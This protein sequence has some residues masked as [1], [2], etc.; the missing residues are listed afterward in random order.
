MRLLLG[1]LSFALLLSATAAGQ[2]KTD[3]E[4]AGLQGAV[5]SVRVE[6]VEL[7]ADGQTSKRPRWLTSV[8][9]YDQQGN[10]LE[11]LHYQPNGALREKRTVARDNEGHKVITTYNAG[12]AVTA[13]TVNSYDDAGHITGTLTYDGAGVLKHKSAS[14]YDE[15]GRFTGGAVYN[16]DGSQMSK[17][18]V[19]F[20]E[21]KKRPELAIYDEHGTLMGRQ[22]LT[23]AGGYVINYRPD[24]T[25]W[26]SETRQPAQREFDGHGNWLKQTW[27]KS[28]TREDRTEDVISVEYRTITYY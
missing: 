23:D 9:T 4:A 19:T 13:K 26:F 3:R 7:A 21:E 18:V 24:G 2:S 5:K 28:V 12:G 27:P 20:D 14:T 16:A 22:A 10:V 8:T 11:E 1:A 17:T 6:Q 15:R 25:I